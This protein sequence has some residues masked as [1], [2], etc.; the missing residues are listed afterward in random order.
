M[1]KTKHTEDTQNEIFFWCQKNLQ[2]KD[3]WRFAEPNNWYFTKE[4]DVTVFLLTW[5]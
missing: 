5:S 3:R 2:G 1:V 4:K